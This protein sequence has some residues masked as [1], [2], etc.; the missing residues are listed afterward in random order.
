MDRKEKDNKKLHIG[1]ALIVFNIFMAIVDTI[2]CKKA[3]YYI[4]QTCSFTKYENGLL[5][6]VGRFIFLII[7]VILIYIWWK[8][9]KYKSNNNRK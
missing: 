3:P 6:M 7:G 4:Q 9:P 2:S 5:Y 8:H 1:I